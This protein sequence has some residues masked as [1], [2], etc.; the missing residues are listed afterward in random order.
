MPRLAHSFLSSTHALPLLAVAA[1]VL[2]WAMDDAAAQ[3]G[4]VAAD[5]TALEALYDATDG[6]NWTDGTNWK[7]AEPLSAWY[8]VTVDG[9][10]R[11]TELDLSDNGLNGTIP[12]AIGD[13]G[14]LERLNLRGNRLS[15]A[16][17][18]AL[19]DPAN[20]EAL[21]LDRNW[22]L[23]GMLPAGLGALADLAE[24]A[25]QDTELCAP[26]DAAFQA[27]LETISFSGLTC[28]PAG[29]SVVDVAV[30][31]TPAVREDAGGTDPAEALI[32]LMAAE[33]NQAFL[34]SGARVRVALV[35]VEEVS[36]RERFLSA[37]LRHLFFRDDG[38]LDGVHAVR[39]RVGADIVVLVTLTR[40]GIAFAMREVSTDFEDRALAV[41]GADSSPGVFAHELGHVMG[42]LHDRYE[43]CGKTCDSPALPYGYG[44][45]NQRGFEPGAPTSARWRTVMSLNGQCE[46]ENVDCV[47]LLRFSN[48][49]QTHGGDPLGA[50]GFA[51][52]AE[53]TGPSNAVRALNRA[54]DVVSRFRSSDVTVSFEVG[55]DT[56]TEGGAAAAVTVRLS[57][58]PQRPLS[59]PLVSR[60]AGGGTALDYDA[61][62]SVDFAAD[63]AAHT[64]GVTAVDDAADDDGETVTFG[65]GAL[66]PGVRAGSPATATVTLADDDAAVTTAPRVL[67]V[68]LMSD[69]GAG[70]AAG[71]VIE[72]G[73][74]FDKPVT[75]TGTPQ[76]AL[77]VGDTARETV[78]AGAAGEV[79]AFAYTVA[80]G[81]SDAGGVSVGADSLSPGGATIEDRDGRAAVPTHDGVADDPAHR[82]DG[83]MPVLQD[84]EVDRE[85]L[86]LT[87]DEALDETSAPELEAFRVTVGAEERLVLRA[88]VSGSAVRIH[89]HP[90][91]V[92]GDTNVAVSYTPGSRPIRDAAGNP[93]ASLSS[94][95]VTN[96]SALP[97]Y[98]TDVDGLIEIETLAQLAAVRH[99]PDGNGVPGSAGAAA[100][101][102]AFPASDGR[103]LCGADCIGYE[104]SESLDFDT[105]G[106]GR[107][108]ADDGYWNGGAGWLPVGSADEPFEATFEGNGHA[109]RHLF[110]RRSD[111]AGLF[112]TTLDA[113]LRNVGLVDVDV[114]GTVYV[115]GLVGYSLSSDITA[116][117]AA[118]SV[119]GDNRVGGLV[120]ANAGDITASYATG[121]VSG[122]RRVGGLAGSS[123]GGAITA[124]YATGPVT[125]RTGEV[126]GL[127]G[128]HYGPS[129]TITASYATGPVSNDSGEVGGLVG[130]L[131]GNDGNDP[132]TDSYWDTRTSGWS[133]GSNGT[134]RT[135]GQ[136]Q[137]PT[138]YSGIY[139]DWNVDLD[140]D[141]AGDSPWD[142]GTN[143][144]YPVLRV[145]FDGRGSA[146]WQGFGRQLREGPRLTATALSGRAALTWT[147]V[148]TSHWSPEPEVTYTATRAGGGTVTVVG[149]GLTGTSVT[150]TGLTAGGSFTYRVSATA[151]GGLATHS[152]PQ[153]VTVVGNRPPMAVGTLPALSLE[154][155]VGAVT[156][157][158]SGAFSD[159]DGDALTYGASSSAVT[160]AVV[161]VSGSSVTVTPL[162]RG[163]STV[164]VTA[165]D[166][167]GSNT[168]GTQRFGVSVDGGG[169]GV[170]GGGGGGGGAG[171]R[172]PE[173]V[174][175]LEDR[176]LE[177]G[178]VLRLDLSAAFLDRDGD[179]LT[180]GAGSSAPE[181]AAV[182]VAGGVVTV[183]ASSAGEAEVTLTATDAAGS[184]RAAGHA[185]VVTVV[186]DADGDGLLGVHTAAQLDAVRHDLDGDGAPTAAGAAR[187]GAAFGL[188]SG[189]TRTCAA[190]GGCAGYELGS[191][192]DL[193][194][195]GSGGP[196]AGDAYWYGGAGWLPL[197]SAAAPFAATFEGN[198]RVVRHLFIDGGDGVGLFGATAPASV[199]RHVGVV[200]ARVSGANAVGALVGL[201]G[202][203][204]TGSYAT[205]RVSG[206]EAA[207]GLVGSIRGPSPPAT[208]RRGCRERRG[209]AAWWASTTAVLRPATRRAG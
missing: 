187:Y 28:P 20:L 207:G 76:L 37:D 208:R 157:E 115:G 11:V 188:A 175:T 5:R 81:E 120:G 89:V 143:A 194:T 110:I 43:E 176:L 161:S 107:V 103:V 85:V 173:A 64:F 74:R 53:V 10:G 70:Y 117:Y 105:D 4:S 99:D 201:N 170:G 135:T 183:T 25:I 177:V 8:G 112:G 27:W 126:G 171:N 138:G 159:P 181:V 96:A 180:Y 174:G 34:D 22:A 166:V 3:M 36:Y 150:D 14:N 21:L 91:V 45:V 132:I 13:V 63:A 156:V 155:A 128:S 186:H 40:G 100:Y 68:A 56:A 130:G 184:N 82:V 80:A 47:S 72:V 116:S 123:S 197:G 199:V 122:T 62:R 152:A 203:V 153:S 131:A 162:T 134:G 202:G 113:S 164:T 26:R 87:Y 104:L 48:P 200:A 146:T 88:A 148:D 42:L 95:A 133:G 7:S 77:T 196:D 94:R 118:G 52:S 41:V 92:H 86:A 15:G 49:G 209:W 24:V 101:G 98:D 84:A 97:P 179:A 178:E 172:G 12:A 31:Y 35:A 114:T 121:S 17:P 71:E 29:Q 32:D 59:I 1:F 54:R 119:S 124:S 125:G 139:A 51:P 55:N 169:G 106:D 190:A 38:Y 102:L 111:R 205:G 83:V 167:D 109:I 144:Q 23:E 160:V 191:D 90:P 75:V 61:P 163:F 65:F 39:D 78:Y 140:G 154:T 9:D 185:F 18:A 93:A 149:E 50:P 189:E 60:G 127:V 141:G 204:V 137:A 192:V 147:A 142:F 16:L 6:V 44:Y 58:A 195:N 69:P 198:G 79:L 151:G 129:G 19:A 108:D 67:M 33:A 182:S 206:A 168:P 66:P 145:D 193:D 158:V 165:T 2:P 73:V 136:L 46:E 30:F 57:A